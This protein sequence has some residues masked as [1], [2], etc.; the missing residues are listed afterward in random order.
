M[1]QRETQRR[2]SCSM[3]ISALNKCAQF[4]R[5]ATVVLMTGMCVCVCVCVCVLGQ[6]ATLCEHTAIAQ[7]L[8]SKTLDIQIG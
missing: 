3:K 8:Q 5:Q 7:G 1:R 2:P 4:V 6:M